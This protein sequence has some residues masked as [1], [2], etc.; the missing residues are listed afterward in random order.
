MAIMDQYYTQTNKQGGILM[1]TPE[2]R[3]FLKIYR[4]YKCTAGQVLQTQHFLSKKDD[5]L[6][7]PAAKNW[8]DILK[9]LINKELI[10]LK[11]NS[12]YMLT[13]DG[14]KEIYG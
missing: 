6:S 9:S 10:Q 13:D 8:Q 7:P 11:S 12:F 3:D 14:E 1:I 4:Y 2:E 5:F